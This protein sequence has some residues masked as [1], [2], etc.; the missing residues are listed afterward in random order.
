M[1]LG[2]YQWDKVDVVLSGCNLG[3]NLGSAMLLRGPGAARSAPRNRSR[4]RLSGAGAELDSGGARGAGVET[5][6]QELKPWMLPP[7]A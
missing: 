5:I 4:A 6:Q 2:A 1:A 3:F 7:R